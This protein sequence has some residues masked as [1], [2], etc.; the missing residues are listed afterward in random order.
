MFFKKKT[1]K[2]KK[3]DF[4][5]SKID[6]SHSFCPSCGSDLKNK[7]KDYGLLGRNDDIDE[8]EQNPFQKAGF[9]DKIIG[10]LVNSLIKN[11]DKQLSQ[12]LGDELENNLGNAEIKTFPNGVRIKMGPGILNSAQPKPSQKAKKPALPTPNTKQIE[13]MSKLPKK[14]Q[15]QK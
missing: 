12:E 1:S 3:C 5:N 8:T 15:N 14:L 7:S 9:T 2:N 13:K 4:C 10:S 11:I 6:K